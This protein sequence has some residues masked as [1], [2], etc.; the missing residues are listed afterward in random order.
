MHGISIID[1]LFP[2]GPEPAKLLRSQDKNRGTAPELT[3]PDDKRLVA[4]LVARREGAPRRFIARH[5]AFFRGV[6]IAA[7]PIARLFVEDLTQEVYVH[8][9]ARDFRVLRRWRHECPLRAYLRTVV[10]RL[11]WERL[12]GLQP[13]RERLANDPLIE[14]GAADRES[15]AT[16]EQLVC[17]EELLCSVR[18]ALHDLNE[19]DRRVIELRYFE[20]LCY[21][22][23]GDEL[24]TTTNAAGVRLTRALAQLK[25]NID[26]RIDRSEGFGLEQLSF[27]TELLSL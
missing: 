23:M 11:V 2:L 17:G 20:E 24:S 19:N 13:A 4:E 1:H 9:W 5:H 6:V 3:V 21:R 12:G 25:A 8:L 26:Q 10:L 14:V 15:P 22:E 18:G 27:R 7:S 16:P